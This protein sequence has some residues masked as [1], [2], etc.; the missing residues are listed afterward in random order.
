[1]K[2][3]IL[4]TV[5]LL[6]ITVAFAKD[7]DGT[8]NAPDFTIKLNDESTFTLSQKKGKPVFLHFWATWCPPCIRE[9]PHMQK[10]Y[11]Q[12]VDSKSNLEFIAVCISDSEKNRNS[13]MQKNNYNFPCG[14]DETGDLVAAKY[15]VSGIPT[16]VLISAEGKLLKINV[17]MMTSSQ[18]EEFV[19]DVK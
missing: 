7:L 16:S 11:T 15:N 3:I 12:L 2:K 19:K 6:S 17:G 1:M 8:Q 14:L 10:L 4:L 9:L 13:F 18:L 5:L